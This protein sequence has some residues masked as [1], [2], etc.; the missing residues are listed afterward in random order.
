MDWIVEEGS[1]SVRI[2]SS[3]DD[4]RLTGAFEIRNT[5]LVNEKSRGFYADAWEE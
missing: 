5:A 1:M 2:G 3:S 4:I